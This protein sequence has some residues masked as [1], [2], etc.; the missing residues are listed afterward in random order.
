MEQRPAVLVLNGGQPSG[1]SPPGHEAFFQDPVTAGAL[2]PQESVPL[3][4]RALTPEPW[5]APP[6]SGELASEP[7]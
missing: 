2:Y 5:H 7:S 4:A 3:R 6:L 1:H